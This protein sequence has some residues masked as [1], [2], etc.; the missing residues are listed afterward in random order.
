MLLV[1]RGW[2][3]Q[4]ISTQQHWAPVP[5]GNCRCSDNRYSDKRIRNR[6]R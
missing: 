5:G 2:S 3:C 1:Q 6:G 4:H